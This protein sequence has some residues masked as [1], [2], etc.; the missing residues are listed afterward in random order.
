MTGNQY[1][2]NALL[3]LHVILEIQWENLLAQLECT[4]L[5]ENQLANPALLVLCAQIQ[6]ELE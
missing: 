4:H 1:V 3:A 6:Q 2:L 5:K